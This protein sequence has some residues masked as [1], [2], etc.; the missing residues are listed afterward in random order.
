MP[1][2]ASF[3]ALVFERDGALRSAR[4]RVRLSTRERSSGRH[5]RRALGHSRVGGRA[6]VR[7]VVRAAPQAGRREGGTPRRKEGE[8]VDVGLGR[9]DADAEVDV[10]NAVLGLAGGAGFGERVAL[11]YD[12]PAAHVQRAHVCE[13]DLGVVEGDRDREAVRRNGPGERHLPRDRC[14]NR[15]QPPRAPRRSRDAGRGRR[16]PRRPRSFGALR[17]RPAMPMRTR[18][19]PVTSAQTST[20][21]R[22]DA[23]RVV[24]RANMDRR[25]RETAQAATHCDPLVTETRG[26]ARCVTSRSSARRRRRRRADPPRPRRARRPRPEQRLHR[27]PTSETTLL[28]GRA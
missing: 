21:P 8:R 10:R 27:R 2:P 12:V 13:R 4:S 24:R 7:A 15:S 18:R 14:T 11:R 1:P 5:C 9:T 6:P 20:T 17:R 22:P 23:H 28:R 16:R 19:G 25:Y 3:G 26:R